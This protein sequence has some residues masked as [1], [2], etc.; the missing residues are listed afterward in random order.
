L[1]TALFAAVAIVSI[2]AGF[3]E[4]RSF[5][6]ERRDWTVER[7]ALINREPVRPAFGEQAET[8]QPPVDDEAYWAPSEN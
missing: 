8:F 5:E 3:L 2:V 7:A 6:R 1:T 4:R